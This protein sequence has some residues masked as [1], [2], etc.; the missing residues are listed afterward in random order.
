M[1]FNVSWQDAVSATCWGSSRLL[2]PVHAPRTSCLCATADGSSS[3]LGKEKMQ[4]KMYSLFFF[5][6]VFN[7]HKGRALRSPTPCCNQCPGWGVTWCTSLLTARPWGNEQYREQGAR[8]SP[9]LPAPAQPQLL[10][11]EDRNKP[12]RAFHTEHTR[13][14]V[15]SEGLLLERFGVVP[16]QES[17]NSWGHEG[18]AGRI[19]ANAGPATTPLGEKPRKHHELEL[20]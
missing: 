5:L 16:Y 14:A 6:V 10:I 1:G 20:M 15:R 4:S 13:A 3:S 9:I 19:Q 7:A 11:S 17:L 12:S 18:A 8:L 2:A